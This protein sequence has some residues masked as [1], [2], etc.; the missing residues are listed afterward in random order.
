M[1]APTQLQSPPQSPSGY[2]GMDDVLIPAPPVVTTIKSETYPLDVLSVGGVNKRPEPGVMVYVTSMSFDTPTSTVTLADRWITRHSEPKSKFQLLSRTAVESQTIPTV[3]D[4]K[5]NVFS[6]PYMLAFE[7]QG[8]K[9]FSGAA[10][11]D[12]YDDRYRQMF[13][14]MPVSASHI[15]TTR[16]VRRVQYFVESYPQFEPQYEHFLTTLKRDTA[17]PQST[18]AGSKPL[19]RRFYTAYF[20]FE[21]YQPEKPGGGNQWLINE[22]SSQ[23]SDVWHTQDGDVTVNM[24][25]VSGYDFDP[26]SENHKLKEDAKALVKKL[27]ALVK[28]M[29]EKEFKSKLTYI[30]VPFG[31]QFIYGHADNGGSVTEVVLESAYKTGKKFR[32]YIR[33]KS[34]V[35]TALL[36]QLNAWLAQFKILQ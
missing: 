36:P 16:A 28:S 18:L 2:T 6:A 34:T 21:I 32:L 19:T 1:S 33:D 20:S 29:G 24:G 11:N 17:T 27:P 3:L 4:E 15:V 14:F 25:I 9:D 30:E 26:V 13:Y 12:D 23:R 10:G 7:T 31:S 35:V 22:T 8:A 5:G